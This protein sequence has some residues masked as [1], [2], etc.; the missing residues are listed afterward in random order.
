MDLEKPYQ[1]ACRE[2]DAIGRLAASIHGDIWHEM[3]VYDGARKITECMN[4]PADVLAQIGVILATKGREESWFAI[5]AL[6]DETIERLA[7][8]R[9][10]DEYS[11][12]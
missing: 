4:D 3:V 1:D 10:E 6:F 2:S 8:S 5:C 12:R 9:A 11:G 7:E